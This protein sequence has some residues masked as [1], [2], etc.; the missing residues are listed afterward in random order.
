MT[1]H[2]NRNWR[3]RWTVD[4]ASA[5]ATHRDGWAFKF[6]VARDSPGA[7]DGRCIAQPSPLTPEHTAQAARIAREA[8]DIY[9]EA[10]HGRH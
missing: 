4:L 9:G 8:G 1:N 3:A 7:F 6:S 2:P 5:T 10:R